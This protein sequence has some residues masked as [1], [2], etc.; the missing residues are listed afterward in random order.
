MAAVGYDRTLK[1]L[2]T[3]MKKLKEAYRAQKKEVDCGGG[4]RPRTNPHFDLLD[5]VLGDKPA[6]QTTGALNSATAS[7][8]QTSNDSDSGKFNVL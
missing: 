5:S 8:A 2:M 7:V 1:Q 6:N 4:G 3:K